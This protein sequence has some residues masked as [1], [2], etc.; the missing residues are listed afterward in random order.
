MDTDNSPVGNRAWLGKQ[1]KQWVTIFLASKITA[2]G[3]CSHEIKRHVLLGRKVMPN[4][5]SI[6]KSR[7]ITLPTKV[8][9]IK[10]M[11]F[12]VVMYGCESWT[13]KKA[14][15]RRIDAFELWCWR[16]LLRVPWTASR[17][18]Q[19]IL[20]EIN[21][22]CSL[23]GLMLKLKL[24][25]FGHLMRRADSFEKTLMLG[26]IEG[27]RRSGWQRMRW[28]MA[29]PTQWTWVLVNSGSWWWTGRPGVLWFMGSQRVRHNWVTE[30]NWTEAGRRGIL[31]G[32]SGKEP[33]CQ[34]RR[35]K[36]YRFD[37]WVRKIPW[38]RTWQPTPV[39]FPRESHQQGS[40]VAYGPWGCTESDSTEMT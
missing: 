33:M 39:F 38:R 6:L 29:S 10:A 4:L 36:R 34:S 17:S 35:C 8:H 5:D 7:D 13:I 12:P 32:T 27:R 16:R 26:K 2:D 1:W 11:V 15:H 23:V 21:P 3:D 14:E 22:G 31:G 28:L 37:L 9:L 25:Y 19:S 40:L 24:Q 18:N 20:K 30:L